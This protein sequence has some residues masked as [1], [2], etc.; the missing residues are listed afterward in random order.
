MKAYIEKACI[1]SAHGLGLSKSFQ[2]LC[3]GEVAYTFI[4]TKEWPSRVQN[5]LKT[6]NIK[7]GASI[8]PELKGSTLERSRQGLILI[9][10]RLQEAW[11]TQKLG[12]VLASTKYHHED[13]IWHNEVN[14]YKEIQNQ[15]H[16]LKKSTRAQEVYFISNA[17]TSGIV[18]LNLAQRLL[19]EKKHTKVL[20]LS[21]D[22]FG[23]FVYS[24]FLSLG[25]ISTIPSKPF[26][27]ERNGLHLGEGFAGV[28]LSSKGNVL[29]KSAEFLND[30]ASA[31]RPTHA[32]K[33]LPKIYKN[34]RSLNMKSLF[35]D[36]VLAHGTGTPHNDKTEMEAIVEGIS[37]KQNKDVFVTASKWSIGHTLGASSLIDVCL[38]T[39]MLETQMAFGV[40]PSRGSLGDEFKKLILTKEKKI[41][42]KN[43]LVQSLGFGGITGCALLEASP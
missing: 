40:C 3:R 23:P 39:E 32:A 43:L 15:I 28:V 26:S 20:V 37:T 13:Y 36:G 18:A 14:P 10:N 33:I 27:F 16:W 29:L 22:L 4:D 31:I 24:G 6:Q 9:L 19:K 42:A 25:A 38:A 8:S 34:L 21:Y 5:L 7:V 41:K 2:A 12:V 35:I 11:S 17:C 30:G 1:L